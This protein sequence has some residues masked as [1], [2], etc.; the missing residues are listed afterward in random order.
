MVC[1]IAVMLKTKNQR[2]PNEDVLIVYFLRIIEDKGCPAYIRGRLFYVYI[3]MRDGCGI[4][5]YCRVTN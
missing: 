5:C 3:L 4:T 1:V 2:N